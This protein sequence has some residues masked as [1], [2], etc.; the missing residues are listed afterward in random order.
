MVDKGQFVEVLL[1]LRCSVGVRDQLP[2]VLGLLK[3][4]DTAD[5]SRHEKASIKVSVEA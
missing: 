3:T 5:M 4:T 2:A 1:G